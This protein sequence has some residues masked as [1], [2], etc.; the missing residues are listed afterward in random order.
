M[1]G[2]VG[3]ELFEEG[4]HR[5]ER[6]EGD[7]RGADQREVGTALAGRHPFGEDGARPIRQQTEE[8]AFAR[9]GGDVHALHRERLAIPWVPGIVDGDRA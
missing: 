4:A 8:R 9:E 6:G 5:E 7:L 1:A 2:V 3:G